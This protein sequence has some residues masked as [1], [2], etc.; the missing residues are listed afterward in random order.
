MLLA[1]RW[2][3]SR[4]ASRADQRRAPTEVFAGYDLLGSEGAAFIAPRPPVALAWSHPAGFTCHS[5]VAGALGA[6]FFADG[7]NAAQPWFRPRVPPARRAFLRPDSFARETMARPLRP[8]AEVAAMHQLNCSTVHAGH[9]PVRRGTHAWCRAPLMPPRATACWRWLSRSVLRPSTASSNSPI[10][11]RHSTSC[12]KESQPRVHGRQSCRR[13]L[14]AAASSLPCADS[15]RL[16][17]RRQT[18]RLRGRTAGARRPSTTRACSTRHRSADGEMPRGR[19]VGFGDNIAFVG[20]LST[21]LLHR[22]FIAGRSG[23]PMGPMRCLLHAP[24]LR[25]DLRAP[26]GARRRSSAG[27][28]VQLRRA[29]RA[30]RWPR[31]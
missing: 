25:G 18:A 27:E 5:P 17:R 29:G 1:P 31:C 15:A 24:R 20:V 14:P 19:A 12:A 22:Q 7:M 23:R 16:L 9:R 3:A 8:F 21:M 2:R 10:A 6:Q 28:R 4:P 26:A 13:R 11:C 30:S